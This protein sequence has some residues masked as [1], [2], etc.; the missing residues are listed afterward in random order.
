MYLL[1]F[2]VP[3]DQADQ[4][5]EAM[6]AAGAGRIGAY[7]YCAWQTVGRGQFRPLA[8][9]DPFIGQMGKLESVDEA[10]VEM[11]CRDEVIKPVIEALRAAHPYETPAYAVVKCEDI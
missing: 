2:Y 4:V 6:F 7:E 10:K 8:G 11:V 5:K 1:S 3:L 9:S